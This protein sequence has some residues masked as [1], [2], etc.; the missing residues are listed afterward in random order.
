MPSSSAET[1]LVL[2]F[3]ARLEALGLRYMVTGGTPEEQ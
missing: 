2:L 3:T 1:N